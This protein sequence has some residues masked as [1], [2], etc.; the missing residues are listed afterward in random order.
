MM[1]DDLEE[2]MEIIGTEKP[3]PNS[4]S[5]EALRRELNRIKAKQLRARY[6]KAKVNSTT[7]DQ[8][9]TSSQTAPD[10]CLSDDHTT[11]KAEYIRVISTP[12][13]VQ[14]VLFDK[15]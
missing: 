6:Q 4:N 12:Y 14:V 1:S 9:K 8:P 2:L 13:G 3:E 10:E 7:T 15:D 11:T 5:K